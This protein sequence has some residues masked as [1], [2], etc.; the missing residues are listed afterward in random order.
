MKYVEL[1][2]YLTD[3]L[4]IES[5]SINHNDTH[6]KSDSKL[7]K[8]AALALVKASQVNKE[9]LEIQDLLEDSNIAYTP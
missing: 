2:I 7:I 3:D 5:V 1:G 9:T 4:G 6:L 8:I